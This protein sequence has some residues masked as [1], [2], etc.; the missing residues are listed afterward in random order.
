VVELGITTEATEVLK[1]EAIEDR[2]KVETRSEILVKRT[3]V[4]SMVGRLRTSVT[5][6]VRAFFSTLLENKGRR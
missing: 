2:Q 5:S 6:V 1:H 3:S 4:S